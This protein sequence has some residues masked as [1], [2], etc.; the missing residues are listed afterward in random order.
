MTLADKKSN[1][2]KIRKFVFSPF[3]ENTYVISDETGE[4]VIIDPG[5]LSQQEKETLASFI[6]TSALKPVALLQT[7]T[8]LDH[9][10]GS[11]YVKRKFGIPMLMHQADLPVL[12]DVELRC[13]TWGIQGYEPVEPDGFLNEGDRY[14]FG[15]TKLDIIWVPGHAPGHIAFICHEDRYIIG[16]DCLFRMSVGRT[17][18]PLCS[19]ADLM[20]SIRDKFFSLPDDYVVYAGHMDETTIGFEKKHNP[21]L[22]A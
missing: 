5:C 19:H 20:Q 8:H 6:E 21:F 7:H 22:N 3:S 11:A 4:C 13:K 12:N 1:M 16:G 14:T 2:S 15:N 9:V 10:F 18:F 17:D